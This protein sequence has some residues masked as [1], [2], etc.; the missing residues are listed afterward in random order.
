MPAL[1]PVKATLAVPAA[2]MADTAPPP[3]MRMK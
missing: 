2:M 3:M 1:H